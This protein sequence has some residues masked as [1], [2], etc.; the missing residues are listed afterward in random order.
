[1]A[2]P[3]V[4]FELE[5]AVRGSFQVEAFVDQMPLTA[6]NFLDL[7]QKGFYDGI[8]IH[9]VL[10][11]FVGQFGCPH[12]RDPDHPA[13]GT[14]GPQGGTSFTIWGT[15]QVVTRDANGKIPDEH[16]ARI[17]NTEMTLSMANRGPNTGGSQVFINFK[18]NPHLDWFNTSTPSA[19]PVFGVV[20]E[21]LDVVRAVENAATGAA[22]G[23][24]RPNPPIMIRRASIVQ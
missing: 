21:G 6:S 19:H 11:A 20:R 10:R 14:G 7:V 3:R 1:M 15:D 18:A 16:T 9:R 22:S 17:P 4:L 8:H 2:N 23:R 13:A 24:D 5:G 12:S